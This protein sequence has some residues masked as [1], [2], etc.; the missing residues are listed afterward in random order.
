MTI[1]FVDP[2]IALITGVFSAVLMTVSAKSWQTIEM[3]DGHL[4][5]LIVRL[6]AWF[7][8]LLTVV[9]CIAFINM[10][11]DNEPIELGRFRNHI[12]D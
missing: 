7:F 12:R 3:N 11:K 6:A 2:T 8:L 9:C 10:G 5:G 1:R 4:A